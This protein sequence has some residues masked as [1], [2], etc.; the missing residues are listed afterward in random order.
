MSSSEEYKSLI[1]CLYTNKN[2]SLFVCCLHSHSHAHGHVY[3]ESRKMKQI[4]PNIQYKPNTMSS[5]LLIALVTHNHI[6]FIH[7]Y[8]FIYSQTYS[9]HHCQANLFYFISFIRFC[10]IRL[11]SAVQMCQCRTCGSEKYHMKLEIE[12]E[13]N[14]KEFSDLDKPGPMYSND[15]KSEFPKVFFSFK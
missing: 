6:K 1:A 5:A 4:L 13:R 15:I 10:D 2:Q 9:H 11:V 12:S 7:K 3:A 8:I 14:K